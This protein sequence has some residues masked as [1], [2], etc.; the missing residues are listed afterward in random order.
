[1]ESPNEPVIEPTVSAY[2]PLFEM[3]A[4]RRELDRMALEYAGNARAIERIV[5]ARRDV[6]GWI[7]DSERSRA[8]R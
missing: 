4:W 6:D 2:S 3:R 1:M 5:E 8:K 7:R